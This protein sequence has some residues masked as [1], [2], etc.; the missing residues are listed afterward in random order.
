[1]L[2]HFLQP[3]RSTSLVAGSRLPALQ[4]VAWQA[5]DT[6]YEAEPVG[7]TVTVVMQMAAKCH[8]LL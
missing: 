8:N 2:V 6:V 5:A 4:E 3:T 1:M 7:D